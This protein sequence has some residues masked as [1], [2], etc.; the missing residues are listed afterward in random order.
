MNTELEADK[1][2]VTMLDITEERK[3]AKRR[4]LMWLYSKQPLGNMKK[5]RKGI[6]EV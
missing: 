4:N 5:Y 2:Q 3:E 6:I 1:R